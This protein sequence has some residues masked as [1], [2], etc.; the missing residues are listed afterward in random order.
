MSDN[1]QPQEADK[2]IYERDKTAKE[3][4]K[5][6]AK[7]EAEAK[8]KI[9]KPKKRKAFVPKKLVRTS[10]RPQEYRVR[11][12]RVSSLMSA[13]LFH[14]TLIDF[15]TELAAKIDEDPDKA[16]HDREKVENYFIRVAKKY[17]ICSS[18]ALGGDIDWIYRGMN[19]E[20]ELITQ[21]LIDTITKTE[22]HVIPKPIK[23]RLGYHIIL[24]C[25]DRDKVVIE[26]PKVAPTT[27]PAGTNIPT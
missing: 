10:E 25:E 6:E 26:K 17:S 13:N 22:K 18:R 19:V 1:K 7:A 4:V 12:I 27:A 2:T 11:Q 24:V 14:Q 23:S 8:P 16:F 20:E 9:Q 21:E 5:A 15:Q 3:P